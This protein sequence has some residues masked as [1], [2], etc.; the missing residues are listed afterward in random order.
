MLEE[1]G[2]NAR[3]FLH[4]EP[5]NAYDKHAYR[6]LVWKYDKLNHVGYVQ[7]HSAAK[8][9]DVMQGAGGYNN[10][11]TYLVGRLKNRVGTPDMFEVEIQGSI[12]DV[13]ALVKREA[14]V[15]KD[16]GIFGQPKKHSLIEVNKNGITAKNY[17]LRNQ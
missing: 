10:V 15:K 11:K 12:T 5:N 2:V 7:R 13:Q 14:A 16:T 6:V 8:I 9:A 1:I 3:V 17:W 4:A